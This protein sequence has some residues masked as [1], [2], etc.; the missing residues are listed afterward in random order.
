MPIHRGRSC[1]WSVQNNSLLCASVPCLN[2]Y[3][4]SDLTLRYDFSNL[5]Y[6]LKM[7][8]LYHRASVR[9]RSLSEQTNTLALNSARTYAVGADFT[10]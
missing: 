3:I 6:C 7:R 2:C 4:T 10:Y 8:L 5:C 9:P 1:E